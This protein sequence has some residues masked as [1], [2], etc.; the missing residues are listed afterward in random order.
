MGRLV[1]AGAGHAHMML[2]D[3]LPDI[4]TKG[5]EVTAIGPEHRH[6]YSG[7]GPGMLGGDYTPEH[8]SFPVRKM[9]EERGGVFVQDKV[10]RIDPDQRVVLTQSGREVPYDVLSCNL[11]SF[12]PHASV[13]EEGASVYTV[14]PIE[15]LLAARQRIMDIAAR[16]RVR[17]AVCGGG[18]AAL[19]IAGNAWAAA[20]EGGRR[21][22]AVSLFAGKNFLK[23]APARV[24]SRARRLLQKRGIEVFE[25]SYVRTV[26]QDEVELENGSRHRA[27]V[28][29]MALGVQPSKVFADSNLPVGRDGGLEVNSFLQSTKYPEIFGGG[30]CIWFAP[31]PLDKV[32][33]YAVRQNPVLLHNVQAMLEGAELQAFDPGGSYLLIYNVGA[34]EGILHKNGIVFGGKPAFWIKDYIDSKFMRR[35]QP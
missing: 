35:F 29:F 33:V 26:R 5:H 11:G 15:N 18:P 19:E 16:E 20:R 1:L 12:V 8:I 21:G 13:V 6:Y 17:V 31:R 4:V 10:T 7:M 2:M 3:S 32:G 30:D 28:I 22:A 23:R 14:K 34:R 25:G 24:R 27:D 9:I